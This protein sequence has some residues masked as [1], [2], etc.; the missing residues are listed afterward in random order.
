M[1]LTLV[2]FA[3]KH[4]SLATMHL[5]ALTFELVDSNNGA[6]VISFSVMRI[7]AE[8]TNKDN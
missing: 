7:T 1:A 8:S 5:D 2:M 4:I 3:F 6:R